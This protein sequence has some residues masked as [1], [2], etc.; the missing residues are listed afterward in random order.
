MCM[1][2]MDRMDVEVRLITLRGSKCF[3][4][5]DVTATENIFLP[6]LEEVS[7][8]IS[9]LLNEQ[10]QNPHRCCLLHKFIYLCVKNHSTDAEY[11]NFSL[12]GCTHTRKTT[13]NFIETNNVQRAISKRHEV[14]GVLNSVSL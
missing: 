11:A 12:T 2:V 8:A 10:T 7:K 9:D 3:E 13:T 14:F 6:G 5:Q 1:M 4:A